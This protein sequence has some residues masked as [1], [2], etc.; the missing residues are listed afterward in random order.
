MADS[1][2]GTNHSLRHHSTHI[3]GSASL[4]LP[5]NPNPAALLR[6]RV[7]RQQQADPKPFF[8]HPQFA[9]PQLVN[10]ANPNLSN[11]SNVNLAHHAAA[12]RAHQIQQAQAQAR[13]VH[14]AGSRPA[15]STIVSMK[16]VGP[17]V[18]QLQKFC[19][20][21]RRGHVKNSL[22]GF[23]K[24]FVSTFFAP[25]ATILLDV[26]TPSP[27]TGTTTGTGNPN[28]STGPNGTGSANIGQN[29]SITI[30]VEAMPRILKSKYD[31]G[32]TDE[33]LLLEMP[34]EFVLENGVNVVDCPQTTVLTSFP[35]SKVCT[36]GHLRV[37][38]TGDKKITKWEFTTRSNEELF[39]RNV[40]G[41]NQIP[42]PVC[43]PYGVP[44]S[45]LMLYAI[46][47]SIND[48]GPTI[49]SKMALLANSTNNN[50]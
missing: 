46:A 38:F 40:L 1:L 6:H 33:K 26:M 34:I 28:I 24:P 32:V 31:A 48:M 11:L 4:A 19:N 8:A 47:E 49:V 29:R 15:K 7:Y 30:P 44:F 13:A 25:N 37:S 9:T 42:D 10:H 5:S 27:N 18:Q 12:R 2:G 3:N 16:G 20:E 36:D 43:T 23:W 35:Q 22:E 41:R 17:C 50:K 21:Q 14:A 45:A 39:T